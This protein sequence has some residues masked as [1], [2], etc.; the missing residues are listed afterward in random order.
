[1]CSLPNKAKV[2]V[3]DDDLAALELIG[4]TL[5][6]LETEPKC[7]QSSQAAAELIEKEKFDG[8]FLDWLM[9][10]L[11][12]LEVARRIRQSKS[13]R[14]VPLIMLTSNTEPEAMEKAFRVGVN[15]F[16]TKPV[17]VAKIRRLL[18]ASRGLML[19]ERRRYR[20]VT[21][22]LETLCAWNGE[23]ARGTTLNLSSC[24][25]LL[26]LQKAPPEKKDVTLTIQ[27]PGGAQKVELV[28]RVVR[29]IPEKAVGI[30]F[31]QCKPGDRKRL[32]DFTEKAAQAPAQTVF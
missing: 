2:L 15:F 32:G 14:K 9:P 17:T 23:H 19:A 12:G 4:Q 27:L 31:T 3:V 24:G 7:V 26:R 25:A 18:D 10:E 29:V 22:S 16:L 28:G 8:I 21:V 1:M 6:S 30:Q 13:N 11:D 20:R 5:K